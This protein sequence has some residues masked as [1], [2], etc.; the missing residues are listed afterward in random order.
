MSICPNCKSHNI[1]ISTES[2][3]TAAA[4]FG[5]GNIASTMVSNN[6]RNF[7]FCSDCGT[8]FRNIQNLEEE[9]AKEL[10]ERKIC[11]IVAI[12]A[13]V[14]FVITTV[15]NQRTFSEW[16]IFSPMLY[17]MILTGVFGIGFFIAIFVSKNKVTKLNAELLY[18][19][20]NCFD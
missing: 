8:K 2:S 13:A 20:T 12:I 14:L 7:W 11:N 16:G 6:H 18:L 19:K 4:T 1:S 15:I 9:I 10:K 17:P 3:V 5:S